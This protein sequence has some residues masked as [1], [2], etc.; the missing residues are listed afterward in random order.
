MLTIKTVKMATRTAFELTLQE[1]K[2]RHFSQSFKIIKVR[3][4][5]SGATSVSQIKQQYQVS[6]ATIYRWMHKFGSMSKK[7]ER[8]IVET[9]SDTVELLA[10]KKRV[11]EL[12]RIVGQKQILIDFKDKMIEIAEEQY[13]VD[14]KKK[15]SSIP[16]GTSGK[17]ENDT[18]SA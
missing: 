3:E 2:A 5:E 18:P 15:F 12:E 16:S 11:A 14:I 8:L 17:T 4:I 7:Q 9:Q 1:R 13:G 6:D 10:L